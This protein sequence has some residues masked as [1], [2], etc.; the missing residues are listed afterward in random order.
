MHAVDGELHFPNLHT[1]YPHPLSYTRL[2]S[3][4]KAGLRA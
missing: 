4:G 2:S 3:Q 1:G